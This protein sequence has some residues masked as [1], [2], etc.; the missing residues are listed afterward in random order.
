[1]FAH[2]VI[3]P[4]HHPP[5]PPG[6]LALPCAAFGTLGAELVPGRVHGHALFVSELVGNWRHGKQG[7][8]N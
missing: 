7:G 4:S 3:P 6:T 2:A 5:P 8:Q 1:M